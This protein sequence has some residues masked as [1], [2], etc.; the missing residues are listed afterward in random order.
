MYKFNGLTE[1][2]SWNIDTQSSDDRIIG[3]HDSWFFSNKKNAQEASDMLNLVEGPDTHFI[4][5]NG[6]YEKPQYRYEVW[7]E[8]FC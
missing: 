3:I 4:R 8:Y 6:E 1:F 7:T 2:K 5:D